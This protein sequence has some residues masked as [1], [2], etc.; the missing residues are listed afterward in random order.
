M[1]GYEEGSGDLMAYLMASCHVGM[2]AAPLGLPVESTPSPA[3]KKSLDSG[4]KQKQPSSLNQGGNQSRGDCKRQ[5]SF[6]GL[7]YTGERFTNFR[8]GASLD[9]NMGLTPDTKK[10]QPDPPLSKSTSAELDEKPHDPNIEK[11]INRVTTMLEKQIQGE[12]KKGKDKCGDSEQEGLPP[13]GQEQA[14]ASDLV[15]PQPDVENAPKEP[16]VESEDEALLNPR[17]KHA[18]ARSATLSIKRSP[19][20][21]SSSDKPKLRLVYP[22]VLNL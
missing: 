1:S 7:E 9:S 21:P 5:L 10:K 2:P 17:K 8:T 19:H 12:K 4:E 22:I 16:P 14:T 6:R 18:P 15:K 20:L 3:S 13:D 11:E